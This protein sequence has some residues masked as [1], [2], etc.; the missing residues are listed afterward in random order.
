MKSRFK[1]LWLLCCMDILILLAAGCN[2]TLRQFI[3]PVPPPTGDPGT[4]A[5]AITVSTNPFIS[6]APVTCEWQ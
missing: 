3:V 4:L 5:H 1:I 6:T 2:D